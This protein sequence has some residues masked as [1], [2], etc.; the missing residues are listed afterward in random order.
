MS[1]NSL[2]RDIARIKRKKGIDFEKIDYEQALARHRARLDILLADN[3]PDLLDKFEKFLVSEGLYKKSFETKSEK[4]QKKAEEEKEPLGDDK[5]EMWKKDH[6][7]LVS[8]HLKLCGSLY[9]LERHYAFGST[10]KK[11][12]DHYLTLLNEVVPHSWRRIAGG[13]ATVSVPSDRRSRP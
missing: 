7:T 3:Q 4:L 8:Y 9:V 2:K 6:D 5:P 10:P 12:W 11:M 13:G 1:L